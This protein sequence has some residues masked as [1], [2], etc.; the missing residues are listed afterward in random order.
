MKKATWYLYRKICLLGLPVFR[1]E[2]VDADL[3]GLYTGVSKEEVR[4]EYYSGKVGL[5]LIILLAGAILGLAARLGARESAFLPEGNLVIREGTEGGTRRLLLAADDGES[6]RSFTVE[7]E[8]QELGREEAEACFQSFLDGPE[9]YILGR[10]ANL[11]HVAFDLDLRESYEGVPLQLTWESDRPDLLEDDGTVQ[12]VADD[13]GVGLTVAW[14]Y[15]AHS[16]TG[17]LNV[18]LA[19]PRLSQEEKEYREMQQAV[20]LAEEESRV[21]GSFRLPAVWEGKDLTW[22]LETKDYSVFIWLAA[23]AIALSVFFLSD[24]DLH[25]KLEKKRQELHREYPDI[26]HR[27]ALYVGAGMTVRGA[28]QKMGRDY[29]KKGKKGGTRPGYEEL[30][31]TCRELDTGVS[32]RTAYERFG[33][34]TGLREYVKLSTLLGQ[35]LK[36]GNSALLERL[37]EEAENASQE[38]LLQVRKSGEEAGTKILVPM[39]MMLGV[40]MVMILVPAFGTM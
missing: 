22:T 40:V 36:R 8:P 13:V 23:P 16:G 7:V 20:L 34:R 29:V 4:A 11:R 25:A 26:V 17:R 24:R 28:F 37:H 39:V 33:R 2:Q 38:M 9:Q 6:R 31:Y 1:S 15:G 19:A 35:N 12:E 32:E 3:A 10:N 5:F 18:T 30:L 21:E 27:L 14:K